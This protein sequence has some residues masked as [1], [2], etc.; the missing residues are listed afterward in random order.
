MG[1]LSGNCSVAI[2]IKAHHSEISMHHGLLPAVQRPATAWHRPVQPRWWNQWESGV[3]GMEG[4]CTR[5]A[6]HRGTDSPHGHSWSSCQ[7]KRSLEISCTYPCWGIS[8]QLCF[9]WLKLLRSHGHSKVMDALTQT[10]VSGGPKA[11]KPSWLGGLRDGRVM[12]Q[13]QNIQLFP[14]SACCFCHLISI[15][16]YFP[17]FLSK[18]GRFY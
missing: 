8:S 17:K 1:L 7:S 18:Q 12:P 3:R 2:S 5:S 16:R 6:V 11:F 4:S 15:D 10:W 13:V 14:S 9:P